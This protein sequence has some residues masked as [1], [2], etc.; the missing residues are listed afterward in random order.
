MTTE[1]LQCVLNICPGS[2]D[3]AK[4]HQAEREKSHSCHRAAKP[5]DLTVG[6]QYDRQI[7]EDSVDWN[8]KVLEGLGASIN[9]NDER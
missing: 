3:R 1:T 5:Q 4:D 2:D 8:R 7:L 6:N 9:H